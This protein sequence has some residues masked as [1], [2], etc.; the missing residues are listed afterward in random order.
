VYDNVYVAD[1]VAKAMLY[2][3]RVRVRVCRGYR[4]TDGVSVQ[5][6]LALCEHVYSPDLH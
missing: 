4:L 3:K 5:A 1:V 6:L 2:P